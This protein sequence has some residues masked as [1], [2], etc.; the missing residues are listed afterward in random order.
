MV[1]AGRNYQWFWAKILPYSINCFHVDFA[2][3][4]TFPDF[5]KSTQ[6]RL[7]KKNGKVYFKY[8]SC[9]YRFYARACCVPGEKNKIR[10]FPNLCFLAIYENDISL[11]PREYFNELSWGIDG[12][13]P[14]K[15]M[16]VEMMSILTITHVCDVSACGGKYNLIIMLPINLLTMRY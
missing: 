8:T 1:I 7:S 2:Q 6:R 4:P 13:F 11:F 3:L 9:T 16:N 5:Q 15:T 12:Y 14:Q 10:S